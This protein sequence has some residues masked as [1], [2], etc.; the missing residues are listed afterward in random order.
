M[1][2]GGIGGLETSMKV[3]QSIRHAVVGGA[4][5]I[6]LVVVGNTLNALPHAGRTCIWIIV[7]GCMV[8]VYCFCDLINNTMYT[9]YIEYSYF[10]CI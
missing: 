7:L 2:S 8:A 6:L 9:Q 5:C 3:V 4:L 1:V 10:N